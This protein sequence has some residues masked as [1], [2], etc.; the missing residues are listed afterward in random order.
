VPTSRAQKVMVRLA[1]VD[2]VD[3]V[4]LTEGEKP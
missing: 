3:E 1:E 2:G 4:V